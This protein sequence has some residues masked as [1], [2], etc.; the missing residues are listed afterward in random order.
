MCDSF[1]TFT[2]KQQPSHTSNTSHT[3]WFNMH[4][5]SSPK[6]SVGVIQLDES[7][8][9]TRPRLRVF[10]SQQSEA[11]V[12]LQEMLLDMLNRSERTRR[13]FL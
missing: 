1:I 9:P 4:H 12:A 13:A 6:M 11:Q 2:E 8:E 5:V 7:K 10:P 3:G